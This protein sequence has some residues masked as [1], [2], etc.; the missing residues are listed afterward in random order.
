MPTWLLFLRYHRKTL[1]RRLWY[2]ILSWSMRW[3][4]SRCSRQRS[5]QRHLL[6]QDILPAANH[7]CLSGSCRFPQIVV[8]GRLKRRFPSKHSLRTSWHLSARYQLKHLKSW[9]VLLYHRPYA[10]SSTKSNECSQCCCLTQD[11]FYWDSQESP[12]QYYWYGL[13][14]Q[15]HSVLRSLL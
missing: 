8:L 11:Q 5:V 1:Y 15:R 7:S 2:Q 13:P 4:S 10:V 3:R 12:D 14:G 9:L 6:M